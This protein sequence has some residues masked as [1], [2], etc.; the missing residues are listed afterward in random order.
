LGHFTIAA[1]PLF[2]RSFD[3]TDDDADQYWSDS[4]S[5]ADDNEDEPEEVEGDLSHAD[6]TVLG[7]YDLSIQMN[8]QKYV[9]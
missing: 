4:E 1:Q 8:A 5:D 3:V 7:K 6:V 2:P 9:T